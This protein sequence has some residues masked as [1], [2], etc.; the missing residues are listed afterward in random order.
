MRRIL[1]L[2]TAAALVAGMMVAMALPAMAAPGNGAQHLDTTS[3][4][5]TKVSIVGTPSGG[6]NATLQ[7]HPEGN[8][9]GGTGGGGAV[10][11]THRFNVGTEPTAV[12]DLDA[13]TVV[14]PSGNVN[15]TAHEGPTK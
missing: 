4:S 13:H 2:I 7:S 5:G 14:T 9:A 8:N 11:S 6:G 15:S 3:P 1:L 10:R 12:A